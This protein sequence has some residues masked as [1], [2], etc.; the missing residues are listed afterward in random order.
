MP[1]EKGNTI[2]LGRKFSEETRQKMSRAH[3]KLMPKD[4]GGGFQKGNI[5]W[6]LP[7]S[8]QR[9]A[10]YA[11]L[12]D[13]EGFITIQQ[14]SPY[15]SHRYHK[16]AVRITMTTKIA[17]EEGQKYWGGWI[18]KRDRKNPKWANPYDWVLQSFYAVKFLKDIL[19]YLK[20]K[21]DQAEIVIE[22]YGLQK[23]KSRQ[24]V[25]RVSDSEMEYRKS[26]VAKLKSLH[27]GGNHISS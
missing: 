2:N 3:K 8:I 26:L 14:N 23:R 21:K 1:F 17:I 15:E 20:E 12:V 5:P 19:P 16:V 7:G 9:N 24:S 25:Q 13:G 6:N 18:Y 27:F 10:Y 11:G 4:W 22:F